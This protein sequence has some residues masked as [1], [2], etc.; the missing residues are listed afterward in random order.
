MEYISKDDAQKLI[1]LIDKQTYSIVDARVYIA[2]RDRLT[3]YINA[4]DSMYVDDYIKQKT[5]K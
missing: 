1:N 4:P 5:S 2:I 3:K